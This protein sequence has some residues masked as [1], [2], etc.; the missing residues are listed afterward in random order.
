[1][2]LTILPSSVNWGLV[3]SVM[4][5][6][7]GLNKKGKYK[8]KNQFGAVERTPEAIQAQKDKMAQMKK[9]QEDRQ[10]ASDA[11]W[12][13]KRKKSKDE[14]SARMDEYNEGIDNKSAKREAERKKK[15]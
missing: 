10:A 15:I 1:M 8:L 12:D 11:E 3:T 7:E 2:R 5:S 9:E 14:M 13:A 4:I 6:P